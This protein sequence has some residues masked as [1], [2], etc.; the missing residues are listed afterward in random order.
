MTPRDGS[1]SVTTRGDANSADDP[2]PSVLK[3]RDA[4]R[5][6]RVIP[7]VG[8]PAVWLTGGNRG[9]LA[10]ALGLLLLVSAAVTAMRKSPA[11]VETAF[12]DDPGDR[13]PAMR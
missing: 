4:Y 8:Y 9:M 13:D 3:G 2:T 10:I 11:L 5:V 1:I 7:L 6:Q 12:T